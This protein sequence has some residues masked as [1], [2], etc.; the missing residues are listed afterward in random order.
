MV[1]ERIAE[2]LAKAA[3]SSRVFPPTDLYNEGWMLRLAL[4]WFSR[5]SSVQHELTLATDSTWYSEALL[6]SAFLAR[7]RGDKLAESWTHADGVIGQFAIGKNGAGDLSVGSGITQ[8]LVTEA[9]IFSKLSPNVTN[10]SYFNQAARSV[11]CIAEVLCRGE[12]D[13]RSVNELGFFVIAP[14]SRIEEGVFAKQMDKDDIRQ[15]VGKRISEY[16]EEQMQQWYERWFLPVLEN[17]CIRCISWEE[18]LGVVTESDRTFGVELA[19]FYAKCLKF[20]QS[21]AKRVPA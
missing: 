12:I 2:M 14:Q 17:T 3:D 10:A 18:I 7:Y 15:V 5:D 4:D 6:P 21:V 11:A 13:A 1:N 20:N 9:K 19:D 8:L 16:Q